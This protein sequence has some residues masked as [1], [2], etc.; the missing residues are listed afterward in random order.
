L[1]FLVDEC[2]GPAVT[3]WLSTQGHDVLSIF[4]TDRA[5]HDAA[6]LTRALAEDRIVVTNDKGF[7]EIIFR[8]G[9]ASGCD[10]AAPGRREGRREDPGTPAAPAP[11]PQPARGQ[12]RGRFRRVGPDRPSP[13]SAELTAPSTPGEDRAL[14]RPQPRRAPT[15]T[16]T[17]AAF[18]SGR[19]AGGADALLGARRG[20]PVR[21]DPVTRRAALP[22][23]VATPKGRLR[24]PAFGRRTAQ[25][26]LGA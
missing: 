17:D 25:G 19:G 16:T 5:A 24:V 15:Y 9:L 12:L 26:P 14:T 21:P 11:A 10:L 2:T 18:G 22:R 20:V 3:R 13:P 6:I 1:R 7:G 23:C 4:H 8:E